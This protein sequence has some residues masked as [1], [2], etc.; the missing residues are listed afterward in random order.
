MSASICIVDICAFLDSPSRSG[1]RGQ[2]IVVVCAFLVTAVIMKMIFAGIK[3]NRQRKLMVAAIKD[4][5]VRAKLGSI[6]QTERLV[7]QFEH[8]D[9]RDRKIELKEGLK[10]L[11][12]EVKFFYLSLER[13]KIRFRFFSKT[14]DDVE[15]M[16]EIFDAF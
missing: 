11:R 15:T 16:F 14:T 1:R 2:C 9:D 13:M 10:K 5:L 4:F 12:D 6:R 8:D 7:N 3:L